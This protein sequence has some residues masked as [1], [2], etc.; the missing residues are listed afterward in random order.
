MVMDKTPP[1]KTRPL[2]DEKRVKSGTELERPLDT[3]RE[4]LVL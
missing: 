3:R 4:A 1:L 2:K